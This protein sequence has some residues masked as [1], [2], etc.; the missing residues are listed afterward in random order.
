MNGFNDFLKIIEKPFVAEM[1]I[2]IAPELAADRIG[3]IAASESM[4]KHYAASVGLS[5]VE[6]AAQETVDNVNL[7]LQQSREQLTEQIAD[8]AQ[9]FL[10]ESDRFEASI[11]DT[12][13]TT[14]PSLLSDQERQVREAQQ[15]VEWAQQARVDA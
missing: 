12:E 15:K 1:P 4:I 14:D 11:G 2:S 9:K 10:R 3:K 7:A 6:L 8:E 5:D 13:M